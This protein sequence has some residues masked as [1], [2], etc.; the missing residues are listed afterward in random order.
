MEDSQTPGFVTRPRKGRF[1][2]KFTK[3]PPR[4]V[5]PPVYILAH[6]NGCP[7][8]CDYCYLQLTFRYQD[9][10]VLFSNR[11][12][13][14]REVRQFLLLSK[15]TVLHAGKLC[16]SL[17]SDLDTGLSKDI[18]PL[19]A[20]QDKHKLLLLTKSTNVRNLLS[21][22][23]HRNTVVSFSL[24]ASEV[25]ERFERGA[26]PPLERLEAAR[27]CQKAGYEVRL[28]LGP[29]IP[30]PGWKEHYK[31][32]VNAVMEEL[33]GDG[34]RITIGT[35]QFFPTLPFHARR[36]GADA[37]VFDGAGWLDRND[38]RLRMAPEACFEMYR[39]FRRQFPENVHVSPCKETPNMWK[40]LGLDPSSP[41]CNCAL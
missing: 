8:S 13:M 12:D 23:E 2:R 6:A 36:R 19:F 20:A 3:I 4:K 28:R 38:G 31:A 41:K 15:P 37:T 21:I 34:L 29:I 14:L 25:A 11:H 5:C 1:V 7:Y 10:P 16:D 30:I 39:W 9:A 18:V 17:V 26:P 24:N 40:R 22:S 32:L 33:H 35:L 27:A